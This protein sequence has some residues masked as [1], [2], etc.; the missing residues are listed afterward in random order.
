MTRVISGVALAAAALAAIV[1]LPTIALRVLACVVAVLAAFEY[2]K[3]VGGDKSY[4]A[5]VLIVTWL[6]SG[7]ALNALAA[8]PV[9]TLLIG[10]LSTLITRRTAQQAIAGTFSLIYI[11]MPLGMLAAIHGRLGWKAPLLL[12]A[13]V[14]VSDTLQYYTGR[15]LGKRP[16]APTISPKKTIEGAVGGVVAGTVFMTLAGPLVFP[17]SAPL[18]LA[19]LGFVVAVMGIAGDL[20]ESRLKREANVKD[21][22]ALIPGHGGILD[23]I[24]ALLF[25][26]P[27]FFVYAGGIP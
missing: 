13:T 24:D 16:L 22:S 23:R 12:I 25:V 9:V 14:V 20:F 21:S 15:A 10:G 1:L 17:G 19:A 8:I 2:V 27:V 4:P 18:G 26:T 7:G 3:I 11:G 5:G 6:V